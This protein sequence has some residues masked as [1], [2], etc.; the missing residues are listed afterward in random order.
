MKSHILI[1]PAAAM[2]LLVMA[3][4]QGRTASDMQPTGDTVEVE[5]PSS[6][7]PATQDADSLLLPTDSL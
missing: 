7:A 1:I 2:T 5:I 6:H 3:A 4:C